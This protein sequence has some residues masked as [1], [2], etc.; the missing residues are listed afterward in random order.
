[1]AI[2]EQAT[3]IQTALWPQGDMRDPLGIW[4]CRLGVTGDASGGSIKVQFRVPA[5][6]KSSYIYTAYSVI[7]VQ[8]TGTATNVSIKTRLLTNWPD[9]DIGVN[10]VQGYAT[11]FAAT[12]VQ[13]GQFTSPTAVPNTTL[14]R[15][16]DRFL[17]LF[18]P[19]PTG[20]PLDIV[21]LEWGENVDLATYSFEGYG[22][23]W[24]R[25]VLN[26]PGGLR[27]PGSN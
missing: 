12:I 7:G 27:H 4:G 24:D 8:L 9:V 26:A 21:E 17:L 25:S 19:R 15:E 13:D 2:E 14:I 10:G 16:G 18:D 23:F 3:V 6:R 20:G 11:A 1:M 5:L 22:Y